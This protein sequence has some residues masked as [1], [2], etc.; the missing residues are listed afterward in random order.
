M[1]LRL[2]VGGLGFRV[3]GWGFRAIGQQGEVR[4]EGGLRFQQPKSSAIYVL[5]KSCKLSSSTYKQTPGAFWIA[6]IQVLK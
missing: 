4:V 3:Y 5:P 2:G 6:R 1:R